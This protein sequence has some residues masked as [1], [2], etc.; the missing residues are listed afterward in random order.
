LELIINDDGIG[1]HDSNSRGLGLE[2][3]EVFTQ[4]LD[5]SIEKNFKNGTSYKIIFTD[6][7]K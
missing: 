1:Y 3:I 7:D 2:L 4:Q 6:Q 5:G